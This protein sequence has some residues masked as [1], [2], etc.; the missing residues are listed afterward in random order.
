M[1]DV[2][3][4]Q[5]AIFCLYIDSYIDYIIRHNLEDFKYIGL[6]N[7]NIDYK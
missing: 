1:I 3:I 6:I 4:K 5:V 2:V 7:S